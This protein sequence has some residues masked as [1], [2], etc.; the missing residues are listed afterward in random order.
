MQKLSEVC[1]PGVEVLTM[2]TRNDVG[3]FRDAVTLGAKD[4]IAKP[5]TEELLER[6]LSKLSP[7]DPSQAVETRSKFMDRGQLIVFMGA[8]GGLGASTCAANA[9]WILAEERHRHV[10]LLDFDLHLGTLA[11]Q[12]NFEP[13]SSLQQALESVDHLDEVS[14]ERAAN[15]YSEH[16]SILACEEALNRKLDISVEAM[17]RL[18]SLLT[19]RFHYTIVDLP[20]CFDHPMNEVMLEKA[21]MVVIVADLTLLSVRDTVRLL[22]YC[23]EQKPTHQRQIVI[24]N[25]V[26]EYKRGTIE[27]EDF[28]KAVQRRIEVSIPFDPSNA[29]E[30][31]NQGQPVASFEGSMA[32]PLR[33]LVDALTGVSVSAPLEKSGLINR[34]LGKFKAS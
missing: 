24:A 6:S 25:R 12:F 11:R 22:A 2:G 29:L 13:N 19:Q 5:L 23:S 1:E 26:G 4:Y 33:K 3:I 9:A 17:N 21:R 34:L 27:P 15:K 32:G 31:L 28:E 7:E 10:S 16:L 14:I 30:A 18:S 8:R 20:L